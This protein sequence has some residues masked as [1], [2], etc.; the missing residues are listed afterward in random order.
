MNNQCNRIHLSFV[1]APAQALSNCTPLSY[2]YFEIEYYYIIVFVTQRIKRYSELEEQI[3]IY[4]DYFTSLA[5]GTHTERAITVTRRP[6][7]YIYMYFNEIS[8]CFATNN[9]SRV[10][11]GTW[12]RSVWWDYGTM[13]W[14]AK[15]LQNAILRFFA[16]SSTSR[17][18]CWWFLNNIFP[19][20]YPMH[21]DN[22][23][24]EINSWRILNNHW[25]LGILL[26]I[27][28]VDLKSDDKTFCNRWPARHN[29]Y[30]YI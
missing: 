2:R 15:R 21:R 11:T 13:V 1:W 10:L 3:W 20:W 4:N 12:N 27:R 5:F 24:D 23:L 8:C 14:V 19:I 28:I 18:C 7:K 30:I 9:N 29:I 17:C 22:T 25:F 26:F 6:Q 16:S